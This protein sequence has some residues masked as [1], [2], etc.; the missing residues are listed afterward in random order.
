VPRFAAE[1]PVTTLQIPPGMT[2]PAARPA[3][4]PTP[5]ITT[6]KPI[7]S[8]GTV[9]CAATVTGGTGSFTYQW[10]DRGNPIG[11]G[12]PLRATLPAGNHL[13]TVTAA[14]HFLVVIEVEVLAH[15]RR[16]VVTV[17]ACFQRIPEGMLITTRAM[18]W[19]RQARTFWPLWPGSDSP[20]M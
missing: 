1:P 6:C 9:T 7:G 4:W 3:A 10:F 15:V 12:N 19:A 5:S 2:A 17:P 11:T 8:D 16:A 13:L 14:A 18:R 20:L